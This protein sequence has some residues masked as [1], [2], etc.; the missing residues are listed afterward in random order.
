MNKRVSTK[1]APGATP[2]GEE[3][4]GSGPSGNAAE[5]AEMMA[6]LKVENQRLGQSQPRL[7]AVRSDE[8]PMEDEE[9]ADEQQQQQQQRQLEVA[10]AASETASG[11]FEKMRN[12]RIDNVSEIEDF[13]VPIEFSDAELI[14]N[15]DG[16]A[17]ESDSPAPISRRS[18]PPARCKFPRCGKLTSDGWCA[19]HEARMEQ[20]LTQGQQQGILEL[21]TRLVQLEAS[22]LK[23]ARSLLDILKKLCTVE[24]VNEARS[25]GA[26][27][28]CLTA[29]ERILVFP[30]FARMRKNVKYQ[31]RRYKSLSLMPQHFTKV[32]DV[33]GF[34]EQASQFDHGQYYTC[35][36]EGM[37]WAFHFS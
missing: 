19:K 34:I 25:A 1:G 31:Y 32:G 23:V 16:S 17:S 11:P 29:E 13:S 10:A 37:I 24:Q 30:K 9:E 12:V 15:S 14:D 21:I 35:H 20:E 4:T 18:G 36:S 8:A 22:N 5:Q 3:S 27:A 2:D 7:M 6:Q 28:L 33:L 26:D